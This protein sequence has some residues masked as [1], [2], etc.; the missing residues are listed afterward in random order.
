[1]GLEEIIE[2]LSNIRQSTIIYYTGKKGKPKIES[3]LEVMNDTEKIL[4]ETI[5]KTEV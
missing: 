1:M 2:Q 4:F 3:Q 5:Q